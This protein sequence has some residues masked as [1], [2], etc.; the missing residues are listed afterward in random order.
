MTKISF[1]EFLTLEASYAGNIGMM[2]M[3][4]FHQVATPAQKVELAKL[5]AS[6]QQE[7]AWTFL[8]KVTGLSLQ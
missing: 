6:G 2:E 1:S 3:F 5:L 7:K 8:Q 4:K